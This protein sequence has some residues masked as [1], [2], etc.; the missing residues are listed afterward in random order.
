MPA[1][2]FKE[3]FRRAAAVIVAAIGEQ[4]PLLSRVGRAFRIRPLDSAALVEHAI[5]GNP[6]DARA[7]PRDFLENLEDGLGMGPL[8][9]HVG[10]SPVFGDEA[11]NGEI[12]Q[13][14]AGGLGHF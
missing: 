2:R 8:A 14:F 5:I 13:G 4:P 10:T 6:R 7:S 1:G 11:E 9:E 3:D 12:V